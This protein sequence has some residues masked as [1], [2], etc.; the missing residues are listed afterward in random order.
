VDKGQKKI[1]KMFDEIAHKYDF[2][3]HL[4]TFYMDNY[5][6][7]KIYKHIKNNNIKCKNILDI[8]SGTGEM[9]KKLVRLKPEILYACDISE[10]MLKLQKKKIKDDNLKLFLTNDHKLPFNNESVDIVTAAFG[11]RNFA[12]L[13]EYMKEIHRILKYNGYFIVLDMFYSVS[14]DKNLFYKFY[15]GKLIPRL[16]NFFSGSKSAYDY[17]FKSVYSFYSVN[18]FIEYC[19]K[20]GFS[21][22]FLQNNLLNTVNTVYLIKREQ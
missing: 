20:F 1:Q 14:L 5:W 10:K 15:F 3:N 13:D 11:I 19:T 22:K 21:N 7:W 16:G 12:D 8:A 6:R 9:T 18:E 2:I 17:L 4:M